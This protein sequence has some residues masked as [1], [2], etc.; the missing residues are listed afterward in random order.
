MLYNHGQHRNSS[1]AQTGLCGKHTTV[2]ISTDLVPDQASRQKHGKVK[3]QEI[4]KSSHFQKIQNG[5]AEQ[6]LKDKLRR[7]AAAPANLL[8]GRD[9]AGYFLCESFRLRDLLYMNPLVGAL[10]QQIEPA[11]GRF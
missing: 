1:L 10:T 11:Q 4:Q 7:P 8:P 5:T 6:L 9:R 2:Y 3:I